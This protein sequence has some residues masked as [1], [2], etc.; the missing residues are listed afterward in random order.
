MKN[1]LPLIALLSAFSLPVAAQSQPPNVTL[2]AVFI[3]LAFN[4]DL[5][6]VQKFA[7]A[8]TPVDSIN[9]DKSTALM[10]AAAEGQAGV[11]RVLLLNGASA[12]IIDRDGDTAEKFARE[13]GHTAVLSLLENQPGEGSPP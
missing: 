3:E 4:G 8:G 13:K 11:V 2:E 10:V 6:N 5:E 9:E 7:S 12:D 1:L